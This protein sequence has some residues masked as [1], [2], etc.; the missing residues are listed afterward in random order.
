MRIREAKHNDGRNNRQLTTT[1]LLQ[2]MKLVL[3]WGNACLLEHASVELQSVA[4]VCHSSWDC[5]LI[6]ERGSREIL[7]A[8]C[9]FLFA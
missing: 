3:L 6:T 9:I 8:A 5:G 1:R 4:L 7:G 2:A